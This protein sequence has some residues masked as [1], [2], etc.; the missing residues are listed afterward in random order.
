[1]TS[2]V[3]ETRLFITGLVDGRVVHAD[4]Q[5][6]A[7]FLSSQLRIRVCGS[8][9]TNHRIVKNLRRLL[10]KCWHLV[11]LAIP[12]IYINASRKSRT[13]TMFWTQLTPIRTPSKMNKAFK[14]SHCQHLRERVF[15]PSSR[16]IS[17]YEFVCGK[18]IQIEFQGGHGNE[19]LEIRAFIGYIK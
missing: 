14:K 2:L 18:F 6:D 3:R 19:K 11:K 10:H 12:R 5:T 4:G 13:T 16:A 9:A 8:P 17:I 15:Q 7:M 1:M